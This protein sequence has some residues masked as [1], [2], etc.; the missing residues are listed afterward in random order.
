MRYANFLR[1]LLLEYYISLRAKC[2]NSTPLHEN[3]NSIIKN[4]SVAIVE[5]IC[6]KVVELLIWKYGVERKIWPLDLFSRWL[7]IHLYI[8]SGAEAKAAYGVRFRCD[9]DNGLKPNK[10][11][12]YPFPR[13]DV[14]IYRQ[15][16]S[17]FNVYM[18]VFESGKAIWVK[19]IKENCI[20]C[21]HIYTLKYIW[22]ILCQI[23][24]K[25]D[26]SDIHY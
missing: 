19:K 13:I 23:V 11:R 22:C 6:A 5:K 26:K 12:R 10:L 8:Y 24:K 14:D 16:L 2:E 17:A 21:I 18:E 15:V 4:L 7:F 20:L 25:H 9:V 3:R 1:S